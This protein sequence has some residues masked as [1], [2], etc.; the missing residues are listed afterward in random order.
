MDR[1]KYNKIIIEPETDLKFSIVFHLIEDL[2]KWY[3]RNNPRGTAQDILV[4][5]YHD[6]SGENRIY[7]LDSEGID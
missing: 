4:R 2:T 3:K 1:R 6:M 7:F 5:F